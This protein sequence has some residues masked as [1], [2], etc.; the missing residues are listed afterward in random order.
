MSHREGLWLAAVSGRKRLFKSVPQLGLTPVYR[1]RRRP[2]GAKAQTQTISN[3]FNVVRVLGPVPA[4]SLGVRCRAGDRRL[5]RAA[6]PL[7][8][9]WRTYLVIDVSL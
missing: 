8:S 7:H 3:Y 1:S 4:I 2:R 6:G 5:P 9:L